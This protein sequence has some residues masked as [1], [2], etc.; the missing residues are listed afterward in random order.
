MNTIPLNRW[1]TQTAD[2]V[3]NPGALTRDPAAF[4]TDSGEAMGRA[5][6]SVGGQGMQV[7]EQIQAREQ[8]AAAEAKRKAEREKVIAESIQAKHDELQIEEESLLKTREIADRADLTPEQ[9]RA[10]FDKAFGGMLAARPAQ[11][12]DPQVAG[13]FK[14]G[15]EAIRFRHKMQLDGAI[16]DHEQSKVSANIQGSADTIGRI[17]AND[18]ERATAEM[19]KIARTSGPAA[20]WKPD[21]VERFVIQKRSDYH[22]TAA[23]AAVDANPQQAIEDLRGGKYEFLD[24]DK[25]LA[26]TKSAEAELDRRAAAAERAVEA[27]ARI[28]GRQVDA[29]ARI[30]DAGAMPPPQLVA[31]T[32]DAVRGTE[33]EADFRALT[34]TVADRARFAGMT[35]EAQAAEV[36]R[37]REAASDPAQGATL[38]EAQAVN[39]KARQY[40]AT[41]K[42]VKQDPLSAAARRGIV[43]LDPLDLSSPEALGTGLAD[44][45]QQ[46]EV[47]SAWAGVEVPPMTAAEIDSVAATLKTGTPEAQQFY[48]RALEMAVD[49]PV[50]Y[51]AVLKQMA[52]KNGALASAGRLLAGDED[53]KKV[54]ELLLRGESYLSVP[55][56][57]KKRVELPKDSDFQMAFDDAAGDA[58]A[59][60][61]QAR[62]MDYR[63]TLRIYAALAADEGVYAGKAEGIDSDRFERA[64]MLA[65]GGVDEYQG[66][67]IILP[68]GMD[69]DA[70]ADKA[71]TQLRTMNKAG[72]LAAKF[73][74]TQLGRLQLE[75]AT[76]GG[77]SGYYVRQGSGYLLD[78]HYR[79]VFVDPSR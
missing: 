60:H 74:D 47:A 65:T 72:E 69:V 55:E 1:G 35:L 45:M 13:N 57:E 43:S 28:A 78:K 22:F 17:Y 33:Y 59:G 19:E 5:L 46:A 20:G 49:D 10:E 31:Q 32:A 34:D 52:P 71:T 67:N 75:N 50:K 12:S 48:L 18:P 24:P 70:L 61:A 42:E 54:G 41:V 79:P 38:A 9:K 23:A 56:G 8:A 76:Q 51:R 58:Y 63:N 30:Y 64:L 62:D 4:V 37:E 44:R 3:Q 40:E 6:S 14:L 73:T 68:R 26:L 36:M 7:A 77:R 21:A 39:W 66:R 27:R 25:R 29:L 2:V 16:R 15:T 53:A 11:F